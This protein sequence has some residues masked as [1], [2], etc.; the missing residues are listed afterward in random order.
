MRRRELASDDPALFTEVAAR[1][2]VGYLVIVTAEGWPRA[3]GLN[4]CAVDGRIYFHGALAGEKH[5]ACALP[6]GARA[7]FT[8]TVPYSM[9]PS[10]WS[11]PGYA[12][13]ATHFFKSVEIKGRC[14]LVDDPAEKARALQA[15]MDKYQPE[16]GFDP[17]DPAEPRYAKALQGVGVYRLEAESW[18]GK[19]KFGQNEPAKLRRRF[20]EELRRRAGPMD[21]E[22]A[23][24][25]E[26]GLGDDA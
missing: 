17:I 13:P 9:I 2:E 24:E 19:A 26:R 10:Y 3:V 12:C 1:A 11:A 6:G 23:D 4:F 7:G 22:T 14:G 25:I 8:M 16:G 18:T 5:A 20:I 21:R 15:L